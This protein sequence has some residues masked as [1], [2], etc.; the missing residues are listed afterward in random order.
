M[1]K[2]WRTLCVNKKIISR[3]LAQEAKHEAYCKP[4]RVE[5]PGTAR[6]ALIEAEGI[7]EELF[8]FEQD[9]WSW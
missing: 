7:A 9:L 1:V 3:L 8:N 4:C 6:N 5:T 2:Q